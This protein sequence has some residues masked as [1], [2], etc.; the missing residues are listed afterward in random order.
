[1]NGGVLDPKAAGIDI[2]SLGV[3]RDGFRNGRLAISA[4]MANADEG[5][6]GVYVATVPEPGTLSI[7]LL[8]AGL[9]PLARRLGSRRV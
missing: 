8:A 1:M 7:L 5:W 4:S 6:A 2:V 9:L 3:E